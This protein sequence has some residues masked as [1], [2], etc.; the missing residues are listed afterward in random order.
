MINNVNVK[1]LVEFRRLSER[2]RS[3]YINELKMP[4]IPK[5]DDETGGNYWVRSISGVSSAFKANDNTIINERIDSLLTVYEPEENNKT[6]I[7]YKRNLEILGEYEDFDFSIW[8]APGNVKFL[9]KPKQVISVKDLPLKISPQHVFSFGTK[10]EPKVGAIWFVIW[11]DGFQ[12]GDLG[13]FSEAQFRYLSEIY[14]KQYT[15]DPN[16]CI[17]VNVPSKEV[18][19]YQ[20]ILDG[21]T[22]SWLDS[23]IDILKKYLK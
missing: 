12:P 19:R 2:R 9:T 13:M 18:V 11:L 21:K 1:E 6:K 23:T 3:T 20:Q 16:Y 14:V 5:Q 17:T 4:K 10:E 15:V 22:P 8:H 7:M